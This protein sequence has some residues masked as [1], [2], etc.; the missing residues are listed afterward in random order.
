MS[1]M[2]HFDDV[3]V[4]NKAVIKRVILPLLA[5]FSCRHISLHNQHP[6]N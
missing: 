3:K 6:D 1:I 5:C 4:N 2:F